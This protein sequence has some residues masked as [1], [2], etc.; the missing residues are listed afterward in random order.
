MALELFD[1]DLLLRAKAEGLAQ[2]KESESVLGGVASAIG[3][4]AVVAG[5]AL[6]AGL[7][8]SVKAAGDFQFQMVKLTGTA[9]ETQENIGLVSQ[10][11]LDMAGQVGYS[12]GQLADGMYLVESAGFH[13]AQGLDVLRASAMAAKAE[14][15]DMA[16]VADA[17]TTA[18]N[19]Y[20]LS[21]SKA[22]QVTDMLLTATSLGKTTFQGL[23]GSLS[24]VLPLA[25]AAHVGLGEVS[26]ALA[27]MTMQGVPAEVAA[28]DL[29]YAIKG[30][31]VPSKIAQAELRKLG[32]GQMQFADELQSSGLKATLADITEQIGKRFPAG[33]AEYNAA[34]SKVVGNVEGLNAILMTTG[35]HTAIFQANLA[36]VGDAGGKTASAFKDAS[37]TMNG[38]IDQ[39]RGHLDAWRIEMG[40]KLLPAAQ[41]VLGWFANVGMPAVQ[42]ASA[43]VVAWFTANWP[44]IAATAQA[45][46]DQIL[47]GWNEVRPM[48]QA[49]L[50]AA[51]SAVTSLMGYL[52][53]HSTLVRDALLAVGAAAAVLVGAVIGVGVVVVGAVAGLQWLYDRFMD[54]QHIIDTVSDAI[55]RFI[56]M[57][58]QAASAVRNV[59]VLGAAL[60]AVGIPGLQLGGYYQAGTLAVVG[61]SGP[62]LFA[63]GVSGTVIPNSQIGG[64]ADM[65]QTNDWLSRATN[66]LEE[67]AQIQAAMLQKQTQG[68]AGFSNRAYGPV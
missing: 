35:D 49:E 62:E 10:G 46:W 63:A 17:T 18:L 7:A 16:V 64:G 67:I 21:G 59:P 37:A 3:A 53:Q 29:Q 52:H 2:W 8:D 57:I 44:S 58:G 11:I 42:N 60:G 13:G 47:A 6:V 32:L 20:S 38:L 34:L 54:V 50:P 56:G 68:R 30:L 24:H 43:A 9:G 51:V 23:A 41:A 48:L 4:V 40:T 19:A 1:I 45:A 65:S 33:T 66:L 26:A 31:E 61:E 36:A 14:N 25:A 15:A 55:G 12:A 5:G 39:V 27:T 28:T 22:T